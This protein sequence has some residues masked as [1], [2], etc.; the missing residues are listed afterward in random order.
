MREMSKNTLSRNFEKVENALKAGIWIWNP[1]HTD[2]EY[3]MQYPNHS[4]N[5]TTSSVAKDVTST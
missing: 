1:I 2:A 5:L 3:K 4:Q